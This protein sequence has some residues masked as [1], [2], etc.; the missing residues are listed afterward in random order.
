[1][2][3]QTLSERAWEISKG[4]RKITPAFMV[5]KLKINFDT[6]TVICQKIWLR[7]NREAREDARIFLESVGGI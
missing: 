2:I 1:M 3:D 5:R 6:A 4:C 7:R